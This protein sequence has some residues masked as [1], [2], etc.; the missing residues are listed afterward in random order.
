M[1]CREEVKQVLS[2]DTGHLL[3][4]FFATDNKDVSVLAHQSHRLV[5]SYWRKQKKL[6]DRIIQSPKQAP[7]VAS[8]M[9]HESGGVVEPVVATRFKPSQSSPTSEPEQLCNS[10][11]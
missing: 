3:Q 1:K 5:I 4:A 2:K 6:F 8:D 10:K 11:V 7:S 9:F